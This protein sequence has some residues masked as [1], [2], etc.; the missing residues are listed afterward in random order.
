LGKT[1]RAN[2]IYQLVDMTWT[3]S[4][5]EDARSTHTIGLRDDQLLRIDCPVDDF[6]TW[7]RIE[8]K[9]AVVVSVIRNQ[10][11]CRQGSGEH[12]RRAF[13][14]SWPDGQRLLRLPTSHKKGLALYNRLRV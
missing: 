1:S 12:T 11:G 4:N 3:G 8:C 7:V 10:E 13:A 6:R 5:F 14:E 9:E 2:Y